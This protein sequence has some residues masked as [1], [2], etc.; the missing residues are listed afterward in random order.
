MASRCSCAS[1]NGE[2]DAALQVPLG[3]L[4]RRGTDWAVFVV[5]GGVARERIVTLGQRGAREAEVLEGLEAGDVIV[6]HPSDAVAEGVT[7][8]D[9]STL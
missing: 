9:R 8:V 1:W 3:A 2:S 5:E 6:T 4:F 7:I